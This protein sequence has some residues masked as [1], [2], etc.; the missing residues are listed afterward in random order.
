[1]EV[2][3]SIV[4]VEGA[5]SVKTQNLLEVEGSIRGAGSVGVTGPFR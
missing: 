4:D 2:L 3:G 5:S 1:M